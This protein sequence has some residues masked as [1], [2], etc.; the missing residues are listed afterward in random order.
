MRLNAR[1]RVLELR[2]HDRLIGR[3]EAGLASTADALLLLVARLLMRGPLLAVS[4]SGAVIVSPWHGH[5][6]GTWKFS[7]SSDQIVLR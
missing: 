3:L 6:A 4:V 1:Q 2:K 5:G 7:T